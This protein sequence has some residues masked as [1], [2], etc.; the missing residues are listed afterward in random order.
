MH[1]LRKIS[2]LLFAAIACEFCFAQTNLTNTGTLYISSS[3]DTLY[4][5]GGLTNNSGAA[6]TNNG[7]LYVSQT[8]TNNQASMNA[9]T[10]TLFLNGSS[11]QSVSGSAV[12][13]TYNLVTD[14]TAGITLD[15]N[16]SVSGLHT[17]V[18]GLIGVSSIPSYLVYEAGS[19]YAGSG[20][21]RHVT[22]WVKKY[23]NTAFTFPV[24]DATYERPV[25]VSNLSAS[26]EIDCHYYITTPNTSNLSTP[27]IIERAAEYWE[28]NKISG[29]TGQ[30]TLNWD[31]SKVPMDNVLLAAILSSQYTSG[32]WMSTG[33]TASG[34]VTTTGSI[35]S[36]P[37]STFG[38]MALGYT[39]F[40]IPLTLISFSGERR[41]GVS[42]LKWVTE[43]EYDVDRF[44]V[45]KS[46]SGGAFT[47]IGSVGGRNSSL[48]EEYLF[49]DIA[50][51]R[52]I[53]YY[54]LK[55]VDIDGKYSYSKI[56]SLSDAD[57]SLYDIVLQN[58]AKDA[59][60]IFNKGAVNGSFNYYL[61]NSSGQ[62]MLKGSVYMPVNG[63]ENI[64]LPASVTSGIYQLQLSGNN[65]N[66]VQK[67][68][69]AR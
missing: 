23:G 25:T 62:L 59:I 39:S 49:N 26:S 44:E 31:H 13:K 15:N 28:V 61:Y 46:Y 52:G 16:L 51:L 27:I 56:I 37:L 34:N 30:V 53:A 35:T 54:R 29:G 32:N 12:F 24:G 57:H 4:I 43:N 8:L 58:P 50:P 55:S 42:A 3:T 68:L 45:Q 7:R 18:N 9:G 14:N 60:K 10:G 66:F 21:S 65:F 6:L 20:D 36:D 67:V 48:R 64:A 69:V 19:S 41:S 1:T 5:A 33:G 2:L 63:A 17:Y 22:S 11:A 40:P 38:Q 47:S